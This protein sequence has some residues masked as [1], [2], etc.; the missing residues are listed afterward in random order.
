VLVPFA[1]IR[2][3]VLVLGGFDIQSHWFASRDGF[4]PDRFLRSQRYPYACS[5]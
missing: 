5:P 1:L 3:V 4:R 2:K